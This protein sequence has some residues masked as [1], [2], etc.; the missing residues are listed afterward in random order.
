MAMVVVGGFFLILALVFPSGMGM[1]DC[2]LAGVIGLY[3][4]WLGWGDVGTGMLLAY[5][6]AAL[7][8]IGLR[9]FG[10]MAARSAVPFAPFMAGGALF[11]VVFVR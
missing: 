11:A 10:S 2:K 1:G 4:G 7:F 8:V 3:L 9:V 5:R 6:V